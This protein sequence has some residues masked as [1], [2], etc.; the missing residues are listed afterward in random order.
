ML[1]TRDYSY[2]EI[3]AYLHTNDC[4]A[5]E[6]KLEKYEIEFA[7]SGRGKKSVYTI[8]AINNPFKVF[9]VFDIGVAP[10]TDIKKF[11]HFLFE[12]LCDE[13]FNGMG[14]EMM[15]EYL[16]DSPNSVSRQTIGTY[17]RR[18]RQNYFISQS[19]S[20]FVYYRVYKHY[21]C[22]THEV[23]TKEEY[24]EA[25]KHYW[26]LRNEMGYESRP[27]YQSMY[28]K[29]GGTP[30]KFG[31][32]ERNAFYNEIYDWLIEVLNEEVGDIE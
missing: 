6:R 2:D 1:E 14:M 22:Q 30:R 26:M 9:A 18:L 21:G 3:T 15:E 32:L 10:Q 12:I 5:T 8:K 16:R 31:V 7:K 11:A 19:T 13:E 27:A 23:I 24:A 4:E 29:F 17:L 25:W 20:D 28:N